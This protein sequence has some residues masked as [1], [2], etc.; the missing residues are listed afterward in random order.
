MQTLSTLTDA[1]LTVEDPFSQDHLNTFV[2]YQG[3]TPYLIYLLP[4]AEDLTIEPKGL[5]HYMVPLLTELFVDRPA[6]HTFFPCQIKG[7]LSL[8]DS[9][10][11]RGTAYNVIRHCGIGKLAEVHL[12]T[13]LGDM[14]HLLARED[15]DGEM[16]LGAVPVS[17]LTGKLETNGER[18]EGAVSKDVMDAIRSLTGDLS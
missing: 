17:Y 13:I 4:F 8:P 12:R 1:I 16:V 6:R 9:E 14:R 2:Q 15:T 10:D 5:L 18:I 3:R 11:V 7:E